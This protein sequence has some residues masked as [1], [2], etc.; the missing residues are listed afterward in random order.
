MSDI[1]TLLERFDAILFTLVVGG[2]GYTTLVVGWLLRKIERN[3][4]THVRKKQ[5]E[6]ERRVRK[7]ERQ[8]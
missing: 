1:L 2:Y 3:H 8:R 5:A 6:L 4:L 7:L